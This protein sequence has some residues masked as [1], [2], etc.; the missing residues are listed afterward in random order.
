[1]QNERPS[2]H[3]VQWNPQI[4]RNKLLYT[5]SLYCVILYCTVFT[6]E[7]YSFITVYYIMD[8]R[9]YRSWKTICLAAHIHYAG[10]QS[11]YTLNFWYQI[12]KVNYINGM[13]NSQHLRLNNPVV[14]RYILKNLIYY[15]RIASVKM[16]KIRLIIFILAGVDFINGYHDVVRKFLYSV[17]GIITYLKNKK[18]CKISELEELEHFYKSC[19]TDSKI[20]HTALFW[21]LYYALLYYPQYISSAM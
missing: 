21:N 19:H 18:I 15:L 14:L 6:R 20:S 17:Y 10:E 16:Q 5:A 1:M 13:K 12:R 3:I 4:S 7:S 8:F 9:L 2:L 11:K